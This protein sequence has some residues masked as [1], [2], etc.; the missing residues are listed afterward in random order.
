MYGGRDGGEDAAQAV[1]GGASHDTIVHVRMLQ[2]ITPPEDTASLWLTSNGLVI[3]T[4][5]VY[6]DWFGWKREDL[7]LGTQVD[8]LFCDSKAMEL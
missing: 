1:S 6:A 4:D 2:V 5:P 8:K 7:P 3:G